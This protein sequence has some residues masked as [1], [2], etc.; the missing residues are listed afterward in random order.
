[1]F[2]KNDGEP[3]EGCGVDVEVVDVLSELG[4]SVMFFSRERLTVYVE[5]SVDR[6]PTE[7]SW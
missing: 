4:D 2:G 1:V 7:G 6:P 5:G 3:I